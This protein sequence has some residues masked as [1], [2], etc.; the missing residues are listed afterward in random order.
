[1]SLVPSQSLCRDCNWNGP[2]LPIFPKFHTFDW[3]VETP[4]VITRS[5]PLSC[6]ICNYWITC[7]IPNRSFCSFKE[8]CGK[9]GDGVKN[10]A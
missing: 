7:V 5:Y 8:L 10:A 9:V 1:M 2:S 6:C 4:D 3:F